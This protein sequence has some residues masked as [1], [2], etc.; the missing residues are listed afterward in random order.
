MRSTVCFFVHVYTRRAIDLKVHIPYNTRILVR[1]EYAVIVL[2]VR[3]VFVLVLYTLY[4]MR[5]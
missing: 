5:P 2:L 4:Y 3:V 1:N